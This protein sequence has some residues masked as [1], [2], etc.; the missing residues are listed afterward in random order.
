MAGN[1]GLEWHE[2]LKMAIENLFLFLPGEAILQPYLFS[3]K[4]QK[5]YFSF[6]KVLLNP[7][8]SEFVT[9]LVRNG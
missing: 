7:N 6:K 8:N 4:P 1:V 3:C 9:S 5:A 2:L